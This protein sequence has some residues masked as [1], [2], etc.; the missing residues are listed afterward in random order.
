MAGWQGGRVAGWQGGRVAGWQGCLCFGGSYLLLPGC[1]TIE[2]WLHE[3]SGMV[4]E[5]A[6]DP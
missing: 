6:H 2:S 1:L 5:E 3:A 4:E